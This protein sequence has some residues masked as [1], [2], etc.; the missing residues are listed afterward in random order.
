MSVSQQTGVQPA[1]RWVRVGLTLLCFE[2]FLLGLPAAFVPHWFF[3]WF[4][5]GRGWVANGGPYNVHTVADIGQPYLGLGVV[6]AVAAVR[7]GRSLSWVAAL[8]ATVANGVHLLFHVVHAAD[9]PLGDVVS[10]NAL[11]ALGVAV[12]LWVMILARRLPDGS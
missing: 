5:F 12:G 6:L 9:M 4:L 8:G 1:G 11:L 7:H 3:D 2:M 10:E